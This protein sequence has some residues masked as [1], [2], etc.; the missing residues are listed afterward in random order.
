MIK[1]LVII[2]NFNDIIYHHENF[3]NSSLNRCIISDQFVLDS[4]LNI[5]LLASTLKSLTADLLK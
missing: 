4:I 3:I 5:A 2:K 1:E